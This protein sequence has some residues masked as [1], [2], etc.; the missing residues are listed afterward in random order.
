MLPSS[1]AVKST[2]KD[3]LKGVWPAAITVGVLL[4]LTYYFGMFLS[5][6]V[7]AIVPFNDTLVSVV[8]LSI[9]L[10]ILYIYFSGGRYREDKHLRNL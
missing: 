1:V 2:A 6:L 8:T 9:Y 3:S 5:E 10:L 4:M 7:K